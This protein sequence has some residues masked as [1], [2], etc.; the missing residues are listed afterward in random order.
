MR[1]YR[2]GSIY[3]M[4]LGTALIVAL[5]A[6]AALLA[7]RSQRRQ[8]NLT[9]DMIQARLNA[10]TGL[11]MALFR[12][13]SN[14]DW[15]ALLAND[16]WD[17]PASTRNGTYS[18][19]GIDAEDGDLTDSVFDSVVITATGT[20]GPAVQ[21]VQFRLKIRQ[22]GLRCLEPLVHSGSDLTFDATTFTGDRMVSSNHDLKA[23]ENSQVYADAEAEHDVSAKDTSVFH[24]ETSTVGEWPREMPDTATVLEYYL[25]NGT[26]IDFTDLPLWGEQRITNPDIAE[27]TTDWVAYGGCNLTLDADE[28]QTPWCILVDGRTVPGDGPCQDVS[29]AI[30]S[31][32]TYSLTADA[33]VVGG[34]MNL[35]VSLRVVSTGAGTQTFSTPWKSVKDSFKTV[36]GDVTPIW[37][38]ELLEAKWTIESELQTL[39][40]RFDDAW[41]GIANKPSDCRVIDRVVLSPTQNPYGDG[42]TN[43]S[44]IY[45]IDCSGK[46]I[47]VKDC[48]IQEHWSLSTRRNQNLRSPAQF[49]GNLLLGRKIR[50]FPISPSCSRT[51]IS[52]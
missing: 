34:E 16:T 14:S 32:E 38:G 9:Q 33:K 23:K 24:K 19:K 39:S 2:R 46:P 35:R 18:F 27:G 6:A 15:R 5:L 7:V 4:T 26:V 21:K 20:C 25:T 51:R 31:G 50:L 3:I 41:L 40:F 10:Q 36:E 52:V 11:E 12:I 22:P 37:T 47:V 8:V 17:T 45:V 42:S 28:S 30:Q 1:N 29:E 13:D 48:R 49:I 43:A 44:G